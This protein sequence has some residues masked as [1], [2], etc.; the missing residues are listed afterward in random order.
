[1]MLANV[2][3]RIRAWLT[4]VAQRL[5]AAAHRRPR[6]F[7]ASIGALAVVAWLGFA[8]LAW[9]T[10]DVTR[11]LPSM[12]DLRSL[13]SMAQATVIYDATDK[14]VFTIFKEQRIEVPL[15]RISPQLINAV[16]ST[17]DLRFYKHTGVDIFRIAGAAL[18]NL[19]HG[20][21]TEGGST[22]TQQL[23]RISFPQKISRTQISLRRKLKEAILAALIER[24]YTKAE[25]LSFYL[26]K[27]Y[28]GDGLHGVEAATQ[29]FFGKHASDVS[30][31]E[32]A[33]VAGVI[34]SPSNYAPTINMEKAVARRNTVLR[35]MLNSGAIDRATYETA[36][37]AKVELTNGLERDEDF[38]QY[39]KE[40]VRRELVTRF[41]WQ[42]VSEGGLRVYTTI[43]SAMQKA[44]ED[45]MET[46]L[47]KIESRKGYKH[48]TRA[49]VR[50]RGSDGPTPY[51]QGALVAMDPATGYVRVMVGGRNFRES[52]FNRATQARRQP[53]SAFKPF[54][55]AAAIESGMTPATLITNLD[56]PI[57]TPQGGW[58]PEDEHSGAASLT[59][60]TALRTSS[61]RAA[62]RLLNTVG[63]RQTVGY[64]DRLNM[65]QM[66]QVPSLALGAAEVTVQSLTSAY[67]AFANGGYGV[68]PIL[69]RRVE[70]ED[71][72]VLATI[73]PE[74]S[75]AFSEQ[76][77]FLVANMLT[78]VINA[79]TAY[80]AR[81][82]GFTL[83]AAGKTGT[84]N[85]YVDA[86][87]VGFTPHLLAGVWIGFDQPQTIVS[88]GY[89][90]ELAVPLWADFMKAATKGDKAEWLDR[91]EGIVGV[92]ICR[93][94]GKRPI[95]GCT[96]VEVV[97]KDGN[98]DVR[99]MV[100]TEYFP[101]NAVPQDLCDLHD[102]GNFFNRLAGIFK[103]G[104]NGPPPVAIDNTGLPTAEAAATA[105]TQP[106]AEAKED[107]DEDKK[108]DEEEAKADEPEKKKKGFWSRIFGSRKKDPPPSQS[109]EQQKPSVP[110][111]P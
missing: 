6:T 77:A 16:L 5:R 42:R 4:P 55:F 72:V 8:Y 111:R 67:A 54:V 66:P 50:R 2:L 56:E 74:Q 26:N 21:V 10:W 75:R 3:H 93:M 68:K 71:G 22:I 45:M 41:G 39:F 108:K 107:K 7:L 19:R 14:P 46:Q 47:T 105:G 18:T 79:G 98:V 87:F 1:M 17:E 49:D 40:Q 9:F 110:E 15:D 59:L 53:G 96:H 83:P 63:M 78:D 20:E 84:T 65:G 106:V 101:R 102:A 24:T 35:R 36:R 94:S 88:N 28:F 48:P 12:S 73:N 27:V 64:I 38:G 25:I 51:L 100:Y 23:G 58:M 91:P 80:R 61:N 86:W 109:Q 99:S 29:G 62:V 34:N 60:R 32:A 81:A 37:G 95:D 104:V 70:D 89:G 57:A 11:T 82:N 90:G 44:A 76:T 52:R 43:D 85:D 92:E 97:T 13:G 69:I 31:A 30:V 33:L 103:P